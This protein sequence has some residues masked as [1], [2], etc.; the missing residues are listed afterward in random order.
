MMNAHEARQ[1]VYENREVKCSVRDWQM[2]VRDALIDYE[3]HAADIGNKELNRRVRA[4]IKR[5]DKKF[6]ELPSVS[7][8]GKL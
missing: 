1:A 8:A 3:S 6:D 2:N 5:L 4:E 7:V